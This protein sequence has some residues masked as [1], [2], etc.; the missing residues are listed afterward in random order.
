MGE[1]ELI[2]TRVKSTK[3]FVVYEDGD[4]EAIPYP[5]YIKKEVLPEDPPEMLTVIIRE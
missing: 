3:N 4:G 2:I 5:I 1:I